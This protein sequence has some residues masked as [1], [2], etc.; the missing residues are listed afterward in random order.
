MAVS[1]VPSALRTTDLDTLARNFQRINDALR[2]AA[3]EQTAQWIACAVCT[4]AAVVIGR[5]R[6]A[7]AVG[8][9]PAVEALLAALGSAMPLDTASAVQALLASGGSSWQTFFTLFDSLGRD[10]AM[11]ATVADS[12]L[13][14]LQPMCSDDTAKARMAAAGNGLITTLAAV[15]RDE[16]KRYHPTA[17]RTALHALI[18][19]VRRS[20]PMKGLVAGELTTLVAALVET[21]DF[22]TQVLLAEL[23]FR[24]ASANPSLFAAVR[25][26]QLPEMLRAG[27]LALP[28]DQSMGD[29]IVALLTAFNA[30]VVP[31]RIWSMSVTSVSLGLHGPDGVVR[32]SVLTSNPTVACVS[33]SSFSVWLG[34]SGECVIV[35]HQDMA[36]AK[37]DSRGRYVM[38]MARVPHTLA[39]CAAANDL[40]AL[41]VRPESLTVVSKEIPLQRWRREHMESLNREAATE[42]RLRQEFASRYGG[43][44]S[45]NAAGVP[46][47]SAAAVGNGGNTEA[48]H[49][50]AV[51]PVPLRPNPHPVAEPKTTKSVSVASRPAGVASRA[52]SMPLA[53]EE[54]LV[55]ARRTRDDLWNA[56]LASAV[57]SGVPSRQPS[58]PLA[59]TGAVA[60]PPQKAH[61]VE[62]QS[63]AMPPSSSYASAGSKP[64]QALPARGASTAATAAE[65]AFRSS[66]LGALGLD[67]DGFAIPSILL[68]DDAPPNTAATTTS[69]ASDPF[70]TLFASSSSS[71]PP[72]QMAARGS[73]GP[74]SSGATNFT[75]ATP[76]ASASRQ[77]SVSHD[78]AAAHFRLKLQAQL[79]GRK[80]QTAN[81]LNWARE[82]ISR[83]VEAVREANRHDRESFD[84]QVS[85]TMRELR[86][87]EARVK[88]WLGQRMPEL[89]AEL[90]QIRVV[91]D[92]VGL[93]LDSLTSRLDA[94]VSAGRTREAEILHELKRKVDDDLAAYED[95]MLATI[96][97]EDPIKFLHTVMNGL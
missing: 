62:V 25:L 67:A 34:D 54:P 22:F 14:V 44:V 19:A 42:A 3:D 59:A 23:F 52:A 58:P 94:A 72:L 4:N 78:D 32:E 73:M 53:S 46:V 5:C 95:A 70:A 68:E 1:D 6:E 7:Y 36:S 48:Y 13:R 51:E 55:G 31:R 76:R 10:V 38:R 47:D 2:T 60:P 20:A 80:A 64:P 69:S 37:L 88:D 33:P 97:E 21:D 84:R 26:P 35:P 28:A 82:K 40:L 39:H 79:E 17:R 50:A 43:S 15:V 45:G 11:G 49:L 85:A 96:P 61:L 81:V 90:T 75:F 30:A 65:P 83:D 29:R 93:R 18:G 56:A 74:S 87:D 89:E 86:D 91:R 9:V 24:L 12:V 8:H 92:V 66:R 27:I 77:S 63:N 41:H 57:P 71:N 16:A